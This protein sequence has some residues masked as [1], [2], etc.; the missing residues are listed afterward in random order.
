MYKMQLSGCA[1][2]LFGQCLVLVLPFLKLLQVP[3]IADWSWLSVLA[4]IWGPGALLVIILAVERVAGAGK[5]L[6]TSYH[7]SEM[8]QSRLGKVNA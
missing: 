5:K 7:P 4:P 1:W 6:V 2:V 8:T 3:G